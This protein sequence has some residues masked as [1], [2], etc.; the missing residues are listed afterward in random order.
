M[1]WSQPTHWTM[2]SKSLSSILRNHD[3][4]KFLQGIKLYQDSNYEMATMCF[5]RAGDTYWKR[6]SK[7][8]GLR[9][10]ADRM[11]HSN[12]EAASVILREAADI[13][14][15]I[16]KAN[17]AALCFIDMEE[18]E[19]A[20]DVYARGYFFMECL[21]VCTRENYLTKLLEEESGNFLEAANIAKLRGEI[22]LVADLLVKAGNF[23]KVLMCGKI[24]LAVKFG[25]S[26]SRI[27]N[28]RG[29]PRSLQE[30]DL[31]VVFQ[32]S[33][34]CSEL[35]YAGLK[36]LK[37]LESLYNFTLKNSLSMF[38][39]SRCLALT[40][41]IAKFLL[42]SKY[43]NCSPNN[44]KALQRFLK[45]STKS[46]FGFRFPLDWRKSL[47]DNMPSFRETEV[48]NNL[49]QQVIVEIIS[50]KAGKLTYRGIGRIVMVILGVVKV[51]NDLYKEIL[52]WIDEDDRNPL[53]K[54]LIQFLCGQLRSKFPYGT[55]PE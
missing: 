9:S 1:G 13:F 48:S 47:S 38:S 29:V 7:A 19:R 20:A 40:V 23:Q 22:L 54:K 49:L 34:W 4:K 18:Y 17:Y 41:E 2:T 45:F 44:V 55:A 26:G 12:P 6:R 37:N 27:S 35:L 3:P 8:A 5:E 50:L 43:L 32:V 42:E 39:G 31:D 46:Y 51:N 53:W 16:G 24:G 21:Q 10:K 14:E 25:F 33:Y 15:A 52:K 30:A 11:H 36:V 28:G